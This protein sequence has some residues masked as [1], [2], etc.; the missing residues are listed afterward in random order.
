M[1][2]RYF[3][4]PMA[5]FTPAVEVRM[6]NLAMEQRQPIKILLNLAQLQARQTFG[7]LAARADLLV[8][9]MS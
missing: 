9:S 1:E 5:L 2:L 8:I 4:E 7:Q 3:C 6:A